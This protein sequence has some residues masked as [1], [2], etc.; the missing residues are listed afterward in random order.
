MIILVFSNLPQ[1]HVL[2]VFTQMDILSGFITTK[3]EDLSLSLSFLLYLFLSHT[4]MGMAVS[5][6]YTY[7]LGQKVTV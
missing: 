3:Q 6:M 4:Q 1:L 2:W 5:N 7:I